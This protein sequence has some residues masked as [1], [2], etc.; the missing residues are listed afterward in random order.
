MPQISEKNYLATGALGESKMGEQIFTL[1]MY[2]LQYIPVLWGFDKLFETRWNR[3]K[4]LIV[5]TITAVSVMITKHCVAMKWLDVTPTEYMIMDTVVFTFQITM[6]FVIFNGNWLKKLFAIMIIMMMAPTIASIIAMAV[7]PMDSD[8]PFNEVYPLG[9]AVVALFI[10]ITT[11]IAVY[12]IKNISDRTLPSNTWMYLVFP[13]SQYMTLTIISDLLVFVSD[14]DKSTHLYALIV[15]LSFLVADIIFIV[16]IFKSTE[17]ERARRKLETEKYINK[18]ENM[19]YQHINDKIAEN[20]KI[21]HDMKNI[22]STAEKL[23]SSDENESSNQLIDML[24]KNVEEAETS[25]FCENKILNAILY[26]KYELAEKNNIKFSAEVTVSDNINI[27]YYDICRAFSNVLD[28]AIEGASASENKEVT[29][30]AKID[31]GYLMIISTN[32]CKNVKNL[33]TTKR[34]KE[35]HGFGIKIIKDIA[36]KYNG[37]TEFIAKDNEFI[38]RVWMKAV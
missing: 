36:A 37:D 10:W 16:M 22:L 24:K 28:N 11:P 9:A 5:L 4:S 3:K 35:N 26:D 31:M 20:M 13:F 29:I 23:I 19:Y 7:T 14:D 33:K 30:K 2:V 12:F 32:S 34:Y 21:R 8:T 15:S 1:V 17:N 18:S 27:D 25:Y 38:C 6:L